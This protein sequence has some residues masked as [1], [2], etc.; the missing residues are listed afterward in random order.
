MTIRKNSRPPKKTLVVDEI[1]EV[2]MRLGIP[3]HKWPGNCMWIATECYHAGL[4]P[5]DSLVCYGFYTGYIHED[6][7][8][9]DRSF[10]HH[11]WIELPDFTIYD[12]TQWAFTC[13][14][15]HIWRGPARHQIYDLGGSR[16]YKAV[17]APG[18]T[19]PAHFKL[20]KA[21]VSKLRK[22]FPALQPDG[23]DFQQWYWLAHRHPDE[24][25]DEAK[26]IYQTMID[27]K[28]AGVI[29]VD[30]KR[31]VFRIN[32]ERSDAKPKSEVPAGVR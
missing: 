27:N 10:S 14:R 29:P 3:T 30:F 21:R 28:L 16:Q 11:A 24:L 26:W 6:S 8:F 1:N 5:K 17:P 32:P 25:G 19:T 12:P 13:R 23:P 15:P 18:V 9:S 20:P 2:V 4:V 31:Y 22:F 7:R